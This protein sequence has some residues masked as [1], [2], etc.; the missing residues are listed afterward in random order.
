MTNQE[1]FDKVATHLLKQGR[2]SVRANGECAYRGKDGLRCAIG[3][4]IPDDKYGRGLE[5]LSSDAGSVMNAAGLVDEN[6]LLAHVLQWVH[7]SVEPAE[8]RE[9]LKIEAESFRLNADVL[10]E[11]TGEGR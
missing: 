1:L 5:G 11:T 8:W 3:V 7:D 10:R 6:S 2:R 9:R 4:L